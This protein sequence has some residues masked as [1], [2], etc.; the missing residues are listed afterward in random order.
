MSPDKNK[1]QYSIGEVG[2][3]IE[4]E[5]HVLRFW[6]TEFVDLKPKKNR[7]G[8]RIYIDHDIEVVKKIKDLL[9]KKKYTIEGA[10]SYLKEEKLKTNQVEL[11]LESNNLRDVVTMVRSEIK[12]ILTLLD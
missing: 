2:K 11:P 8:R 4:L 9:H 6:E 7:A 1:N 5:P 3:M 10:K 12:D